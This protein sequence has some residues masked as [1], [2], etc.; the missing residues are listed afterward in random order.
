MAVACAALVSMAVPAGSMA[1]VTPV[2]LRVEGSS[3]TLWDRAIG[4]LPLELRSNVGP[5][6]GV[7]PCDVVQNG[8]TGKRAATPV[9]ALASIPLKRGLNWYPEYTGFM[10]TELGTDEPTGAN[11]WDFWVNGKGA[12]DLE[13]IGGCQLGL[14]KG[15]SVVWAVTDGSH[16]LL[17]LRVSGRSSS[18]VTLTA[19]NATTGA[20]VVGAKVGSATTGADGKATV[21]RPARGS[22]RVKATAAGFIR[23]NAVKVS[24]RR[25]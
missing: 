21:G 12:V 17:I 11:Y 24:A 18:S 10:V 5:N 16:S 15:D 7:Y 4:A 22:V 20:P 2:K 14:K 6:P 25:R 9:S 13:Y 8:G 23:S 19:T 3:K 1:A